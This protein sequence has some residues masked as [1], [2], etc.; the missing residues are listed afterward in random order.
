MSHT[1]DKAI[2]LAAGMGKRISKT[3]GHHARS[4]AIDALFKIR[5]ENGRA[6]SRAR[7]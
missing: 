7:A 2:I 5:P 1:I 4:I 6:K 3:P